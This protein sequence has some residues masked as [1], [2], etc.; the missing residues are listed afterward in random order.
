LTGSETDEITSEKKT[1]AVEPYTK[2]KQHQNGQPIKSNHVLLI[3]YWQVQKVAT[4]EKRI[5]A[6]NT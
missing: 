5:N 3:G 1:D 2:N 4:E 6:K